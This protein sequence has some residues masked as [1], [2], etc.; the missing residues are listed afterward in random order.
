MAA[1]A[2]ATMWVTSVLSNAR[3]ASVSAMAPTVRR[4]T[5]SRNSPGSEAENRSQILVRL[6][7]V[8][9]LTLPLSPLASI[10]PEV[11]AWHASTL[12]LASP[13]RSSDQAVVCTC[14]TRRAGTRHPA[15]SS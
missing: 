7:R 13:S 14:R 1:M 2:P 12:A 5:I 9:V 15:W 3:T 8:T 6:A 10:K 4:P 11:P